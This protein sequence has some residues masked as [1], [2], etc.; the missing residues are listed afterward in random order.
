MPASTSFPSGHAASAAAFA[1]GVASA[2]PEAGIPLSAAAALVAYSRVHTG[3]HYPVDVIAGSV[4][5]SALAQVVVSL[6]D[7]R[8]RTAARLAG[9][10]SR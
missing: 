9:P 2:F 4:T 8:R 5:G 7:H 1:T 3:V 6:L 10:P